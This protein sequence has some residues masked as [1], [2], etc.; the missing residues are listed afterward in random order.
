[1]TLFWLCVLAFVLGYLFALALTNK[2]DKQEHKEENK[3]PHGH[4][5]WDDCPVCGH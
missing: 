1:M 5:D 4:E 3:C 2:R